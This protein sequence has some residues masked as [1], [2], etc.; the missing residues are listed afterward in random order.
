MFVRI[1][2]QRSIGD[3][4]SALK[5]TLPD[6][7]GA[8]TVAEA[9]SAAQSVE[10]PDAALVSKLKAALPVDTQIRELQQERKSLSEKGPRDKHFSQ[11]ALLACI[12][13]LFAIEVSL[14][15][16]CVQSFLP[17]GL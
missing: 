11:G 3:E 10:S 14:V 5:K 15:H 8:S 9:L 17:N 1:D 6:L 7:G 16:A 13:T 12:G 2:M 4:I